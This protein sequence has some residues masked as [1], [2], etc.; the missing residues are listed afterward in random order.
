MILLYP[1][2]LLFI[3]LEVISYVSVSKPVG[4]STIFEWTMQ[5]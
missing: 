3:C 1:V 5:D 4:H 2:T